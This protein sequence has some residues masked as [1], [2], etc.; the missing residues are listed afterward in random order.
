M[1]NLA[2]ILGLIL[3]LSMALAACG[4]AV[5]ATEAPVQPIAT[6]HLLQTEPPAATE[7]R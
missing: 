7:A 2:K 5:V 3:G 6:E 4:P 1:K